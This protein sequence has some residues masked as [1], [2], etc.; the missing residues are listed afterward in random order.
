M[1]AVRATETGAKAASANSAGR[2]SSAVARANVS[3][4]SGP[5][6]ALEPSAVVSSCIEANRS[7]PPTAAVSR[8][9]TVGVVSGS[10]RASTRPAVSGHHQT[11]SS[12]TARPGSSTA[13]SARLATIAATSGGVPWSSSLPMKLRSATPTAPRQAADSLEV[14]P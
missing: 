6:T 3:R 7:A 11:P 10:V 5:T 2:M 1:P 8:S 13:P 9:R 14:A 4:A 12:N